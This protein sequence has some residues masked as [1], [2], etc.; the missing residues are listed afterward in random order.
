M[1]WKLNPD[2]PVYVQLIERIT[3]DIIAGIYPPGSKLPSVRDLAQTAGVNPNTMQK[4]LSEMERTNLVYSQRTSGRFITEDLSMIDDLKTELA[5][6]Q[7]KEFL[8]K[9]EKIDL[10]KEDIIGLINKVS[11]EEKK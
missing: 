2:R 7:I 4:A 8:E 3:T 10:S 5:S 1:S 11:E 9:M 6:E